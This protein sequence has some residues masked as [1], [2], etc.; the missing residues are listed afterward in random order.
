ME[1]FRYTST[2]S[3]D[4]NGIVIRTKYNTVS[5]ARTDYM[6]CAGFFH[7]RKKNFL[8]FFLILVTLYPT[9]NAVYM[10]RGRHLFS[11]SERR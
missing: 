8:S 11:T 6:F 2:Q 9:F 4:P 10:K 5:K 1:Y 3:I 7:A